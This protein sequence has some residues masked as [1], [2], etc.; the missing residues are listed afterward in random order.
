[1]AP[2]LAPAANQTTEEGALFHIATM[3]FSDPEFLDPLLNNTVSFTFDVDWGDGHSATG[4]LP[5]G[6][7][8]G[9]AGVPTTGT[10]DASHVYADDGV[11]TVTVTV[12]DDDGGS[13]TQ[14][15]QVTVNNVAPVA[16]D[17]EASTTENAPVTKNVIANDTDAGIL[18]VLSLKPGSAAI[19]SMFFGPPAS[20]TPV[21]GTTT[22]ATVTE[23]GNEITFD[24]GTD[25]DFLAVGETATALVTYVVQDD[26]TPPGEDTGTLT[27]TIL[28]TNDAPEITLGVGDSDAKSLTESN[29]GLTTS[30]T[31]TVTDLDVTDE[32]NASVPTVVASGTAPVAG[33]PSNAALLAMMTV[34]PNPVIGSGQTTGTIDWTFDSQGQAFDYLPQGQTLILEYTIRVTD[35]QGATDNHVVTI[36]ITGTNDPP[37]AH[38]GGPYTIA[39]GGS[40]VLDA[41]LTTDPDTSPLFYLWD[42][43]GDNNFNDATGVNPTLTWAQLEAIGIN[44]D[45]VRT[46]RVRVIDGLGGVS[47]AS[48]TLTITNTLP[49]VTTTG[50]YTV[51]EGGSLTLSGSATDP[52][53]VDQA[54]LVYVWYINVDD[55]AYTVASQSPTLTWAQLVALGVNDRYHGAYLARLRVFDDTGFGIADTTIT[56]LNAPPTVT[57][58]NATVTVDEGSLANNT[59]TFGDIGSDPVTITAS[60]GSITQNDVTKTW[61]WSYTPADGPADSQTVTITATDSDDAET[62]TTFALVVNN[63][64][65]TVAADTATVTVDEGSPASNTGTYGDVGAD[66]VTITASVGSITQNDI[67]K[68]WSWSYTP[69]DG[70]AD[71]QTVTITAT[72]SDGA[73]TTATFQLI[74]N[75]VPPTVTVDDADVTVDE[76]SLANNTGTFGD[77]G[78]DTVTITASVGSIT[79]DDNAGTWSWSYT[80]A[81]GPADSQTVTITAT[82]SDGAQT[83]ATF[84]LIVN[85]VPPTVTVDDAEVTVNEGSLASNTGTFG[86]VGA[87]TVTITASVGSITQNDI[88][89]TWSWSYTPADGPDDSQTVTITA[90]DSDGA[91]TTTTFSLV[92]N[93]VPPTVA[94]TN[95]TVTVA[96]GNPA[97]NTGTFGDVGADTVT[98]TA[99]VGTITQDNNTETWS[100][101]Y[102][103][104]VG[105]SQTVTITATD[106]DGAVSTTTFALVVT[107]DIVATIAGRHIF[108]NR[109]WFDRSP[110]FANGDPAANQYDDNA[111]ATDKTPLLPGAGQATFANYTSYVRGINGI[112]IDIAGLAGTPTLADFSFKVGNNNTPSGWV[113]GPAPVSITV[114]PG[115]GVGGS[116]RVT[117]IWND[118]DSANPSTTAVA[119]RWLEIRVLATAN[120]GLVQSDVFY[121]GNAIGDT[122]LGNTTVVIVNPI[123]ESAVRDNPRST[124]SRAPITFPYDMNRD[125]LVNPTDQ[126]IVRGNPMS[127]LSALRYIE[128][129]APSGPEGEGGTFAPATTS[130]GDGTFAPTMTLPAEGNFALTVTRSDD[131][132]KASAKPE[133]PSNATDSLMAEFSDTDTTV[134]NMS[135]A[136]GTEKILREVASGRSVQVQEVDTLLETVLE[137]LFAGP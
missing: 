109:S 103:P 40:L 43:N 92:V 122:G 80:P 2:T 82:D 19:H 95:A 85:N 129:A 123:D 27:I 66:T 10:F 11:Y 24:P 8:N 100:W 78:A 71:S 120:T 118:Y 35:S 54:N 115:A 48:A 91:V 59:G 34:S 62:T 134:W 31:L 111:I 90:T 50:P 60:V 28:G 51:V 44:N 38:A 106:S 41:S 36:T 84:Q 12:H 49:T 39:E 89:K 124:L 75:N 87:D 20:P 125:G 29:V 112:M 7:V 15:F 133:E 4:L 23:D 136:W 53:S 70:P 93:N 126:S 119:K 130:G 105:E 135:E 83:T 47:V 63:V 21:V 55:E 117:L 79:Q 56:V 102:T 17:D 131:S 65:P 13:A 108:Y 74:V 52:S 110:G 9:S 32:V 98:I 113:T 137:E 61:S 132:Q 96:P 81:D 57:V 104:A 16:V 73:Q 107:E 69:A 101:S 114:R 26:A 30:G 42:V 121:V 5:S 99:S 127:G 72:D 86:D 1:V 76:G 37:V 58:D 22:P 94:A 14:T 45:G 97:S 88:S 64:P 68:T 46:V 6:V 18:D 33:R 3:T 67:A 128:I 25:F 77:V 116:D